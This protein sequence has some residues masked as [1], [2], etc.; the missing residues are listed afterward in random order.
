MTQSTEAIRCQADQLGRSKSIWPG[1]DMALA[2]LC[3]NRALAGGRALALTR[4]A[5]AAF[6]A[7]DMSPRSLFSTSAADSATGGETN[8]RDVTVSG[9]STPA[10]RGGG[11]WAWRDLR[12]FTPFRFVDGT[13]C[14]HSIPSP[15]LD[16]GNTCSLTAAAMNAGD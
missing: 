12:D 8:R 16:F 5:Y 1:F 2:R 6:P 10:R 11:R 9:Q 14:H 3:L 4:P 7:A 13:T 15:S